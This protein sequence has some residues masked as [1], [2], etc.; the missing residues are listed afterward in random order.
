MNQ[1]LKDRLTG[2]ISRKFILA[3]AS[4]MSVHWLMNY[5]LITDSIYSTVVLATV[6][7]YISGNVFQKI[8]SDEPEKK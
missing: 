4:L 3:M 8:K 7:V 1:S 2:L 6:A 5:H